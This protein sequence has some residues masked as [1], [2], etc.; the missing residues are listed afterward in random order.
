M[1][2]CYYTHVRFCLTVNQLVAV[3]RLICACVGLNKIMYISFQCKLLMPLS[4]RKTNHV[5]DIKKMFNRK[6][7]SSDHDTDAIYSSSF[8]K[9]D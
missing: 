8:L 6:K 4:D 3:N 1:L 2:V 7:S 9:I 5:Y